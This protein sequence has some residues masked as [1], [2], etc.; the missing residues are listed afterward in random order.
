M[1]YYRC[2]V[3]TGIFTAEA[4]GNHPCNISSQQRYTYP[5]PSIA[6]TTPAGL[7]PAVSTSLLNNNSTPNQNTIHPSFATG[8]QQAQV[9]AENP[10]APL[11]HPATIQL[12][13]TRS[14]YTDVAEPLKSMYGMI[15]SGDCPSLDFYK[16]LSKENQR[17][18]C[19]CVPVD[20]AIAKF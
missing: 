7:S 9:I 2:P 12:S 4:I 18:V 5:I 15:S 1:A 6:S 17:Q 14:Y 20:L 16:S 13:S 19:A 10:S 8:P 3:C 11:S